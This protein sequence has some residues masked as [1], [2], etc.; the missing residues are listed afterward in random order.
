MKVRDI[1]L[2]DAAATERAG[3]ALAGCPGLRDLR[4]LHL[5]GDLG[6]GKTTLVRGLLRA[7]GHQGT[8]RS[9][10]YTLLEPYEFPGFTVLH[11]DLYRV[12]DPDELEYL[13]VREQSGEGSLWL[14]EWPDR[15][16]G[17]LPAPDLVAT[18]VPDGDG[19]RLRLTGPRAEPIS[20][21]MMDL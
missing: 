5:R 13:G 17:W 10:T 21:E 3:A 8:V 18:L 2:P 15:G 14:V 6:A 7:L 16:A 20:R 1:F 12:A 9:P 11:F 19:R 4:Q